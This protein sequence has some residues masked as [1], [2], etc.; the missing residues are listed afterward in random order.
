MTQAPEKSDLT[1]LVVDDDEINLNI[2]Q[3]L[4]AQI[5]ID[6]VHIALDG[7]QGLKT[8]RSLGSVDVIVVDVYM[9]GMDGIE[10]I[11]ELAAMRFVGKVIM[12]SGVNIET[13]ALA[14]QIAQGSGIQVIATF[15]KPLRKD[16]MA[17]AMGLTT[18]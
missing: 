11:S 2:A 8:L 15:E 1:V 7:L 6:K 16:D 5:G 3:E 12:V 10:F 4:L 13:L 17:L 14:R 18:A 9:P